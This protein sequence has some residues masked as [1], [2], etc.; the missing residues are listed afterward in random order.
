MTRLAVAAVVLLFLGG[1]AAFCV[2]LS[3]ASLPW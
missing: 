3:A 2:A 1:V